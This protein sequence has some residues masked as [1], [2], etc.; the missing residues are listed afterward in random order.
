M[1][2]PFLIDQTAATAARLARE[3][4]GRRLAIYAAIRSTGRVPDAMVGLGLPLLAYVLGTVDDAPTRVTAVRARHS[5]DSP[6]WG[7]GT[8]VEQWTI[9]VLCA[10]GMTITVDVATGPWTTGA[11]PLELRVEW[12][13]SERVTTLHPRGATIASATPG[14]ASLGLSGLEEA[15]LVYAEELGDLAAEGAL[16]EELGPALRIIDAA[17]DSAASGLPVDISNYREMEA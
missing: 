11:G 2:S 3:A 4:P 7:L 12:M 8:E 16:P 17:G 10:S 9:L 15:L 14:D 13:T 1:M 6:F 5:A